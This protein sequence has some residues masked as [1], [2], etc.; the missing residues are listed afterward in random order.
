MAKAV[1]GGK[2]GDV[3]DCTSLKRRVCTI[4]QNFQIKFKIFKA[5]IAYRSVVKDC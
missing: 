5:G 2:G 1:D 3:D 4:C